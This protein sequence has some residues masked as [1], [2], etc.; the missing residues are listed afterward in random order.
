MHVARDKGTFP[1]RL[2]ITA[3][4]HATFKRLAFADIAQYKEKDLISIIS[5]EKQKTTK[6]YSLERNNQVTTVLLLFV[7]PMNKLRDRTSWPPLGVHLV[8]IERKR[9][10][11]KGAC[12]GVCARRGSTYTYSLCSRLVIRPL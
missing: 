12:R 10:G 8:N 6:M 4:T 11:K 9:D 5:Q 1:N 7:F 3:A 2:P